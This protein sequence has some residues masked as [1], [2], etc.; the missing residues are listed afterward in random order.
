MPQRLGTTGVA[1]LLVAAAAPAWAAESLSDPMS[2]QEIVGLQPGY[3]E[4]HMTGIN[5]TP[6]FNVPLNRIYHAC[7]KSGDSQKKLFMPQTTGQ[8]QTQED[9]DSTGVMHWK[10]TCSIVNGTTQGSGTVSTA[11][12]HFTSEWQVV[13]TL[14]LANGYSTTANMTL[15]GRHI[16]DHCPAR[17]R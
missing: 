8:C 2:P 1:L 5:H 12:D 4:L 3:W 13:S 16:G 17:R 7:L 11:A 9:T 6:Q 10:W 15:V 14:K